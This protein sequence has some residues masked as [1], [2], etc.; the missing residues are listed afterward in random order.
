M[1]LLVVDADRRLPDAAPGQHDAEEEQHDDGADVDEYLGDGDELGAEQ[2]EQRGHAG[3][4]DDEVER[5]VHDVLGGDDAER[6]RRP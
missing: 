5:G 2:E 4:H 3:E 1:A 6:A